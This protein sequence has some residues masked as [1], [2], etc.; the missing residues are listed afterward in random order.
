MI[1]LT[2][3]EKGRIHANRNTTLRWRSQGGGPQEMRGEAANNGMHVTSGQAR[4]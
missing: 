3:K 1:A 4:A 2:Y